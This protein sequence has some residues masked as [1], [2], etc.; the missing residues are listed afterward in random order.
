MP[1]WAHAGSQGTAGTNEDQKVLPK[2]LCPGAVRG[3]VGRQ[4]RLDSGSALPAWDHVPVGLS[5][6]QGFPTA[7]L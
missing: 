5:Q 7:S 4:E 3:A 1:P 6:P 2:S